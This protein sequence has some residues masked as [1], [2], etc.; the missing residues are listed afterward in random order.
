L[1]GYLFEPLA[2]AE[3]SGYRNVH[4]VFTV[5]GAVRGNHRHVRGTEI[6]A[7]TGPA[8]VRFKDAEGVH[9]VTVPFGETWRFSFPPGVSHAFCNTGSE[10]MIL[11]S[12]NTEEHDPNAPDAVRDEILPG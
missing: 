11:A 8:L 1:R 10:P 7:V 9:D 4:V 6:T 3:L 12:F 2:A 5:P